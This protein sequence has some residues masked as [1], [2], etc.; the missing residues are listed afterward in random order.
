MA[1]INIEVQIA[2]QG[3]IL[4]SINALPTNRNTYPNF[5]K[6]HI[7][8]VIQGHPVYDVTAYA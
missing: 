2:A 7:F 5:S 4:G 8:K 3:S 1:A 6:K